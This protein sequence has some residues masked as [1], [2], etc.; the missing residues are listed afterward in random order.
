MAGVNGARYGGSD[1]FLVRGKEG[2]WRLEGFFALVRLCLAKAVM[3]WRGDADR[4]ASGGWI[5]R[6]G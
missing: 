1:G 3:W 6:Y 4:S 5:E 2:E